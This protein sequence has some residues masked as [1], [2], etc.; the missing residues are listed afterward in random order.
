MDQINE[1]GEL[2]GYWYGAQVLCPECFQRQGWVPHEGVIPSDD[3]VGLLTRCANCLIPLWAYKEG[4][5]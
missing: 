2:I 1:M 3:L 4:V 5:L